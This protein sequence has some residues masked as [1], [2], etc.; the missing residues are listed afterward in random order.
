MGD[1]QQTYRE[2]MTRQPTPATT[3]FEAATRDFVFGE[4]WSR[5]GPRRPR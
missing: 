1:A 5:P 2:V 4:V 3:P